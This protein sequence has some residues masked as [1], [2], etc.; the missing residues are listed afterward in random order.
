MEQTS[1]YLPKT[2]A[3][4]ASLQESAA[5]LCQNAELSVNEKQELKTK[6][7]ELRQQ[8][9]DKATCIDEII[10]RLNGAIK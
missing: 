6:L 8:L 5:L 2:S 7:A 4:L 1:K 10:N 3:A 9:A